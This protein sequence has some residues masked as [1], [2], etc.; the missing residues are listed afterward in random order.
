MGDSPDKGEERKAR[1][2]TQ[3]QDE[4]VHSSAFRRPNP[5][6]VAGR[7]QILRLFWCNLGTNLRLG[8]LDCAQ[9]HWPSFAERKACGGSS[10]LCRPSR[11]FGIKSRQICFKKSPR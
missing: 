10:L 4:G 11:V 3:T 8:L 1:K 6:I 5:G 2:I 9:H 7:L